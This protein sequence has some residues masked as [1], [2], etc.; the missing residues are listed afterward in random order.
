MYIIR[1]LAIIVII[2]I[3]YYNSIQ[4]NILTALILPLSKDKI[5]LYSNFPSD[6][7]FDF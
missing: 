5:S 6:L 3:L 7:V 1:I 2:S 4:D